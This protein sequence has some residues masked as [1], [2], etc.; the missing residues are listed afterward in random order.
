MAKMQRN[1]LRICEWC[2]N[3]FMTNQGQLNK[4]WG[5][6]CSSYCSNKSKSFNKTVELKCQQCGAKYNQKLSLIKIS[7]YCSKKC[8]IKSQKTAKRE[9]VD[10]G[11][12][13]KSYNAKRCRSCARLYIAQTKEPAVKKIGYISI[14][15]DYCGRG[16][17][18]KRVNYNPKAKHHY[19]SKK[20]EGLHRRMIMPH[21]EAHWLY[22][23][24]LSP[25]YNKIRLIA[26]YK[27][28]RSLVFKRDNYT[29]VECG[30]RNNIHAHHIKTVREI[31]EENNIKTIFE[32]K[33]CKELWDIDNGMT[34]CRQCHLKEHQKRK[35]A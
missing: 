23:N 31:L 24:G 22:K 7:R 16:H 26:Q 28:W 18:Q 5:K 25:L 8:K 34:L 2:G 21:G 12:K 27:E 15:C 11:V 10:C 19:C 33:H 13:L 14:V 1:I 17:Q 35:V 6:F 32:A 3:S 4:G 30:G 20:C 29:C 9:C